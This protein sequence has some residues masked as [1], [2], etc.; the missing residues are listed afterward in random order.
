M[1]ACAPTTSCWRATATRASAAL[2]G[3]LP[4]YAGAEAPVGYLSDQRVAW[5]LGFRSGG[6]IW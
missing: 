5:M 2:T 6:A 3:R 4:D 1:R